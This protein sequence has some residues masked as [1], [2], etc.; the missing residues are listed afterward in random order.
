MTMIM[1]VFGLCSKKYLFILDCEQF[2]LIDKFYAFNGHAATS[3]GKIIYLSSN[4]YF[5]NVSGLDDCVW[6][7]FRCTQLNGH[8]PDNQVQCLLFIDQAPMLDIS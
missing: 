1:F 8:W 2:D 7:F 6:D 5:N 4:K 3:K